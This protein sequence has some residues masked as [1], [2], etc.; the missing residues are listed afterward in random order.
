MVYDNGYNISH[1]HEHADVFR[2][3]RVREICQVRRFIFSVTL[4]RNLL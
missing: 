4:K 3:H 2:S 1:F